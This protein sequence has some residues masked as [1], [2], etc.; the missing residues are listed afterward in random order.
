MAVSA[1]A[2]VAPLLFFTAHRVKSRCP[3]CHFSRALM[4]DAA[5]KKHGLRTCDEVAE[6]LEANVKQHYLAKR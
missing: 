1:V 3:R 6:H 5:L 2:P 4:M